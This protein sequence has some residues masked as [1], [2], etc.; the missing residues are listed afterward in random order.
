[1]MAAAGCPREVGDETPSRSFGPLTLTDFVRYQGASG[2]MNP[3]HHDDQAARAAGY[4]EAF[5]VGMLGAGYLATVCIDAF[6]PDSVR[7]FTTRFRHLIWRGD[8]LTATGRVVEVVD[9][10]GEP[11]VLVELALVNQDGVVVT[12]GSARFVL[13][14]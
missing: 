3:M 8:V 4:R 14:D 6:G 2:D 5:G 9:V 13:T 7:R 11:S 10:D 12:E 1:M